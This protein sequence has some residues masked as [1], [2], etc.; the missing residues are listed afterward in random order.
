MSWFQEC[1]WYTLNILAQQGMSACM[2]HRLKVTLIKILTNCESPIWRFILWWSYVDQGFD[3]INFP[4]VDSYSLLLVVSLLSSYVEVLE[5]F[6]AKPYWC[7]EKYWNSSK[8]SRIDVERNC[9]LFRFKF[10]VFE[11]RIPIVYTSGSPSFHLPNY[12][13]HNY[14]SSS[15]TRAP[16]CLYNLLFN[17]EMTINGWTISLQFY[18]DPNGMIL[19][20]F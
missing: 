2:F 16:Q 17:I 9:L 5:L 10:V 20:L 8:L 7:R 1:L 12:N 15:M 14:S 19:W 6:Q 11:L 18:I 13:K 3:S 4:F